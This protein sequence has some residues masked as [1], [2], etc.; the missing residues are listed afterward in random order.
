M[1][2]ITVTIDELYQVYFWGMSEGQVLMEEE[3]EIEDMFDAAVCGYSGKKYCVPSAP[4]RRRQIHSEK[5][6]NAMRKAKT[7]FNSF[8]KRKLE[9]N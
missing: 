2:K 7:D 6:F 3:R 1:K 5:W 4:A 8:I 9:T